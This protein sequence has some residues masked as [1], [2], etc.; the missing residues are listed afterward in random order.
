MSEIT[1]EMDER[2]RLAAAVLAASAWPDMEQ[3]QAPHAVHT[4]SK[5]TRQFVREFQNTAVVTQ[6]NEALANGAPLGRI[7]EAAL[8]DAAGLYADFGQRS[9]IAQK[10][11]PEQA[12]VW[13]EALAELK[14]IFATAPLATFLAKLLQ[15]PLSKPIYVVPTLVYP[16][17]A[18]VVAESADRYTVIMPP[19][20]AWGESPPWP[21]RDE[22]SWVLAEGCRQMIVHLLAKSLMAAEPT[23]VALLRHGAATLFIEECLGEAESMAYLVRA[24][25]QY[26]LPSLPAFVTD[27]RNTI[28]QTADV[29]IFDL[30]NLPTPP[31]QP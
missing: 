10:L 8:A 5:L 26:N 15:R 17:L 20:K 29:T 31:D 25:R 2:L 16:M 22:V 30:L 7:F 1:V 21:Y 27:L 13:D 6:V 28:E 24:K 23:A 9:D 19:P 14:Q 18:A 11:W 4:Q 12:A 3:A